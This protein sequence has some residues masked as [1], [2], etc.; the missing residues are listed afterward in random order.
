VS[1]G[2]VWIVALV[3]AGVFAGAVCTGYFLGETAFRPSTPTAVGLPGASPSPPGQTPAAAPAPPTGPSASGGASEPGPGTATVSPTVPAASGT[4]AAQ[5][6][7]TPA[8][9]SPA[10][11]PSAPEPGGPE[12]KTPGAAP[13]SP[14]ASVPPSAVPPAP[15]RFHV[16]VGVFAERQNAD[17]LLLRLRS[18]GYAVTL[19]EGPP[20]RVWV[21]GYIDRGTAVRLAQNLHTA[22]FDAVLTPQ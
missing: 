20:Y 15:S 14:A 21:G 11:L 2:R 7:A 4:G 6:G 9:T 3:L 17:A 19:V 22:G 8:P 5:G 18:L 13:A 1:A 10:P 16:Q 12:P